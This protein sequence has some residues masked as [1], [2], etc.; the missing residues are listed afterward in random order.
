MLEDVRALLR[1]LS[2]ELVDEG[3]VEAALF[4]QV[5]PDD[6]RAHVAMLCHDALARLRGALVILDTPSS[7]DAQAAA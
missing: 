1:L 2:L 7:S 4:A 3:G 6:P 5:H